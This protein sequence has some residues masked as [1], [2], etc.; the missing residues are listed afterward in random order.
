MKISKNC[1]YC[2][3]E[4]VAHKLSTKYCSPDCNKK[5]YKIRLKKGEISESQQNEKAIKER[6]YKQQYLL[7][8]KAHLSIKETCELLG[9]SRTTLYRLI[10]N[11]KLKVLKIGTRI[12]IQKSDLE[13]MIKSH[14][15]TYI[16]NQIEEIKANFNINNYYYIGEIINIYGISEK[17][18]YSLLINHSVDKVQIGS[19]TYVLKSDIK[20]LLGTPQN[21]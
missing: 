7:N 5:H 10:K 2:G 12:I 16:P 15:R 8:N 11:E 14:S 21:L 1:I 6:I 18:L 13:A 19:Y 9:L 20:K 17:G 3:K 4:F